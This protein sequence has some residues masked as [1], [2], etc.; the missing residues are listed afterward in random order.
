[1]NKSPYYNMGLFYI[2]NEAVFP[3]EKFSNIMIAKLWNNV[4]SF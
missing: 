4:S 3:D 1:M 2:V